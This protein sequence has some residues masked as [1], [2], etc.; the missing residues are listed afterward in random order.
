MDLAVAK[1]YWATDTLGFLESLD[2]GRKN[3]SSFIR[4]HRMSLALVGC[5][6]YLLL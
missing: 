3:V 4:E 1:L 6:Q 2:G 5:L